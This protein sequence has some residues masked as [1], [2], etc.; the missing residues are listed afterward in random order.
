LPRSAILTVILSCPSNRLELNPKLWLGFESTD[1][2][3]VDNGISEVAPVVS[4]GA[5]DV[6]VGA[7]VDVVVPVCDGAI[8]CVSNEGPGGFEGRGLVFLLNPCESI[9]IFHNRSAASSVSS[10]PPPTS[11]ALSFDSLLVSLPIAPHCP[12]IQVYSPPHR[13]CSSQT[14]TCRTSGSI[15]TMMT[16]MEAVGN[17]V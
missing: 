8:C 11:P 10:S 17:C 13:S 16:G 9:D 15:R 5:I 3:D 12:P 7:T 6:D 2:I 1:M 4:D 14:L